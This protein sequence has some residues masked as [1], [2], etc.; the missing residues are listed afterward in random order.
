MIQG[1]GN[2]SSPGCHAGAGVNRQKHKAGGQQS[3]VA[4]F[5]VNPVGF[6][7]SHQY[8]LKNL[9]YLTSATQ[10]ASAQFT[11]L[12][13]PKLCL[14]TQVSVCQQA[15]PCDQISMKFGRQSCLRKRNHIQKAF[16]FW[17]IQRFSAIRNKLFLSSSCETN[18]QK[19]HSKSLQAVLG[20]R[21]LLK[22]IAKGV[23]NHKFDTYYHI[24][25]CESEV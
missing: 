2:G 16:G 15:K 24:K 19:V 17:V 6:P 3:V 18:R 1:L 12:F 21:T 13:F 14:H 23:V 11:K 7:T 4:T 5:Q 9:C 22:M 20:S 10:C 25:K 8:T